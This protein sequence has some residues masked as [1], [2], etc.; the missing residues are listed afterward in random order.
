MDDVIEK[1]KHLKEKKEA[2][3]SPLDEFFEPEKE[4]KNE[5]EKEEEPKKDGLDI[6][7]LGKTPPKEVSEKEPTEVREEIKNNIPTKGIR[8]LSF[9]EDETSGETTSQN[10]QK[11]KLIKLI[12][13]LLEAEQFE[14]VQGEIEKL[15][16]I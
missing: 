3:S 2:E 5:V 13:A 9:E 4:D 10:P 12:V 6:K 16:T 11:V 14:A 15:K 1:L 8:E 7:H